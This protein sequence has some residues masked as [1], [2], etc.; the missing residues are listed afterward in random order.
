M[1]T[2]ALVRK[3][4]A[5]ENREDLW[6]YRNGTCI[7][8]IV[9]D[10]TCDALYWCDRQNMEKAETYTTDAGETFNIYRRGNDLAV[11]IP[12]PEAPEEQ[13]EKSQD[14]EGS[15]QR[16]KI[17]SNSQEDNG[18]G[19]KVAFKKATVYSRIGIN[20]HGT[21]KAFNG[22]IFEKG[23]YSFDVFKRDP[24][25]KRSPYTILVHNTGMSISQCD[26]LHDA[27]E[28]I[29]EDMI[30]LLNKMSGRLEEATKVYFDMMVEHGYIRQEERAEIISNPEI[31]SC[32]ERKPETVKETAEQDLPAEDPK[33]ARGPVPEKTFAGKMMEGDG[34]TIFFDNVAERTRIIFKNK[35]SKKI[36]NLVKEAGFYWSNSMGSWNKKLTWKAFR[37]AM[38]LANILDPAVAAA[39][40]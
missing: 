8:M 13:E 16:S 30:G 11:A 19:R 2:K 1:E 37:S 7:S 31:V 5:V 17:I 24:E 27:F 36:L 22:W 38:E 10:R 21:L 40:K 33:A 23:G 35:P 25:I 15:E 34:W 28:A 18:A 3:N 39:F 9:I 4:K 29:T 14:P 26:K 20:G 6:I 12:T 32:E